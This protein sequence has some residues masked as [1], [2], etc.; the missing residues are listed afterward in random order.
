MKRNTIFYLLFFAGICINAMQKENKQLAV[1]T[2]ILSQFNEAVEQDWNSQ[3]KQIIADAT[4]STP[5]AQVFKRYKNLFVARALQNYR[6]GTSADQIIQ[7]VK[8]AHPTQSELTAIYNK[9]ISWGT[10]SKSVT[11]RPSNKSDLSCSKEWHSKLFLLQGILATE[12][13]KAKN[14]S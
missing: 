12:Y 11:S 9:K 10:W 14:H 5:T 8:T 4:F 2:E 13:Y 7:D 3:T 6:S 1:S